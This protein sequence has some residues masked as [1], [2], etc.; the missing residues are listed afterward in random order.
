MAEALTP[1]AH[2]A[3]TGQSLTLASALGATSDRRQ[4]LEVTHAYWRLV[5]AVALYHYSLDHQT[6]LS[7]LT[8]RADNALLLRTAQVSA[9][10]AL[11]EAES[12]AVGSQYELAAMV[13]LPAG[14]PLPL[15]G[16]RPHVGAYRTQVKELFPMGGVPPRAKLI[17]QTLPYLRRAID[18][19]ALAVT[20]AEEATNGSV[21]AYQGGRGDLSVALLCTAEFHR[22]RRAFAELVCRYNDQIADYAL[23]VAHVNVSGS[24]VVGM[25]IGPPRDQIRPMSY[26]DDGSGAGRPV[27]TPTRAVPLTAPADSPTGALTPVPPQREPVLAPPLEAQ[28]RP[29]PP[30][31]GTNAAPQAAAPADDSKEPVVPG[32]LPPSLLRRG[33]APADGSSA[34]SRTVHRVALDRSAGPMAPLPNALYPGLIQAQPA[35]KASQLAVTLHWD[36]SLPE[37]MGDPITLEECL[38][39]RSAVER[40]PILAAY[41]SARHRAAECQAFAQQAELLEALSAMTTRRDG[42]AGTQPPSRLRM[43]QLSTA[44]AVQESR[45]SLVETQLE[46]AGRI[47]RAASPRWPLPTTVP[48][49]GPSLVN[50]DALSPE[51]Q[52]S[53]PVQRW[54]ALLPLQQRALEDRAVAVIEA[55]VARA[56]L[57][58][59]YEGAEASL[60]DVLAAVGREADETMAFLRLLTD[61]NQTNGQYA[62][63]VLPPAASSQQ[64]AAALVAAK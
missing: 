26:E 39:D 33:P 40:W 16:D 27:A 55:D 51:L 12:K 6:Q 4:Q 37:G 19:R 15:P 42:A 21:T 47:G 13:M 64:L 62:L 23:N 57:T 41:W 17:D 24:A 28:P 43:L 3:L 11:R 18:S 45:A 46:L 54:A 8:A 61:Y 10:A 52:K 30:S 34:E 5:E 9:G 7:Q 20:A 60:E 58:A 44:A 63:A 59:Q 1:R 49:A 50:R 31:A 14:S 56:A 25:L 53:R 22:Q 38:R 48:H 32:A 2:T 36:R 35:A 29:A